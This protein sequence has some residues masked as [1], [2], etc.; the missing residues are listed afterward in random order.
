M[1]E[2]SGVCVCLRAR[3]CV[4]VRARARVRTRVCV[5]VRA[6][7]RAC[8]CVCVHMYQVHSTTVSYTE[9]SIIT[10]HHIQNSPQ[11]HITSSGGD[12]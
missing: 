4:C 9:Y 8:A 5:S 3:A 11:L 12:S 6:C 7:V 1:A 10:Y 2:I